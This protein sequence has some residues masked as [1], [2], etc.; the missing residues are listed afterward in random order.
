[1]VPQP[2]TDQRHWEKI[3][4]YVTPN[5]GTTAPDWLASL[6]E[7]YKLSLKGEKQILLKILN[8]QNLDF[9]NSL[10]QPLSY[11]RTTM[12]NIQPWHKSYIKDI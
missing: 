2:L 9:M 6:D 5:S 11:N 10:K 7:N 12:L 8:Y 1:M 3:T 4:S